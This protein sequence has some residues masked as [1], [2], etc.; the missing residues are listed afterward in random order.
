[1]RADNIKNITRIFVLRLLNYWNF[2]IILFS[3]V[4]GV[5]TQFRLLLFGIHIP[6]EFEPPHS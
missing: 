1:M 6:C 2:L 5:Q 3:V 4:F